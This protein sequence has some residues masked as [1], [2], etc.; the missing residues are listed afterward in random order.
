MGDSVEVIPFKEFTV[1][2]NPVITMLELKM[3]RDE[4]V[5]SQRELTE[6]GRRTYSLPHANEQL[7]KKLEEED[8][9]ENKALQTKLMAKGAS[10]PAK[11]SAKRTEKGQ[12]E[13]NSQTLNRAP[14]KVLA[15][16]KKKV[17]GVTKQ[18]VRKSQRKTK[19]VK[20]NDDES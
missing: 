19:P 5:I 11:P 4:H 20:T 16:K 1:S 15:K 7:L 18:A 13:V 14:E 8:N 10:A 3:L 12:R 9:L 2:S 17:V 6:L